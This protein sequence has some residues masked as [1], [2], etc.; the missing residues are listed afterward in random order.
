MTGNE[1]GA[2]RALPRQDVIE[3]YGYAVELTDLHWRREIALIGPCVP[4]VPWISMAP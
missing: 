4:A 2:V 1:S 3:C